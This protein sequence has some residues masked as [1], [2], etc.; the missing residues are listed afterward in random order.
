MI[1]VAFAATAAVLT[2]RS[3]VRLAFATTFSVV[4]LVPDTA[5]LPG[6]GLG[7]LPMYRIALLALLGGLLARHGLGRDPDSPWRP[8][9]MH[10]AMLLW[11]VG[12]A[13]VGVA[14]AEPGLGMT[15]RSQALG[16]IV[17]QL[18]MLVAVVA[19]VRIT[20]D[21]WSIARIIA[22]V[23]VVSVV[24]ATSERLFDWSY[25]RWFLHRPG[26]RAEV[27][28]V[29]E[30]EERGAATRVRG[31]A[32]FALAY[33]WV[34]VL[35]LPSLLAV[36]S[37][38]SARLRS[39]LWL[40]PPLA[41]ATIAWTQSRS[42]LPALGIGV[43][44]LAAASRFRRVLVLF[45]IVAA[46][47]A[48][49][50][51]LSSPSL[52]EPY[53]SASARQSD[54][55]RADRQAI[56]AAIA[57]ER[58]VLGQGLSSISS[59]FALVGLDLEF[60]SVF[61]EQ[62]AVGV[63]LFGFVLAVALVSC[64]RGLRA[65]PGRDRTLSAAATTTVL[66]GVAGAFAFDLFKV[67]GVSLPFWAVVGLGAA[68]AERS[69]PPGPW[70]TSER[71]RAW[72]AA[73]WPRVRIALPMAGVAVGIVLAATVPTRA[74][75]EGSFESMPVSTVTAA[76]GDFEYTG[77]L[78][79]EAICDLAG[80]LHVDRTSIECRTIEG[81]G[82][83]GAIAW[84]GASA[85]SVRVHAFATAAALHAAFPGFRAHATTTEPAT[86][87]PPWATTAPVWLGLVGLLV[88]AFVPGVRADRGDRRWTRA[89]AA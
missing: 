21:P 64:G 31:A 61:V 28:G 72:I 73:W 25:A 15:T 20:R 55:S 47:G 23:F 16:L 49:A 11:V 43:V 67:P 62:G 1:A 75:W 69:V 24:I 85:E 2:T 34:S 53:D 18:L 48:G 46:L 35:L 38:A 65:P 86:D 10:A 79:S 74:R 4:L 58:P 26:F 3:S 36:L 83:L 8:N 29:Q 70:V 78:L 45:A 41:A 60:L 88:A 17:D 59:R 50:L 71:L 30:L 33:A 19:V 89:I 40:L 6:P 32:E 57:R 7:N 63:A 56:G 12:A 44:L 13:V 9:R 87:G 77:S 66:L 76:D 84:Q 42:A 54:E 14:A 81:S 27:Q 80:T 52:R 39:L 82:G 51:L 37:H 22:G 5:T 68:H